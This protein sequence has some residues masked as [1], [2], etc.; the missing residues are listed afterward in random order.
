M[1]LIKEMLEKKE[2][3]EVTW[4]ETNHMLADALTKKVGNQNWIKAVLES[5]VLRKGEE[6]NKKL[7]L[8]GGD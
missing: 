8:H 4:V 3:H 5:N 7:E 6:R 2:V 1:A